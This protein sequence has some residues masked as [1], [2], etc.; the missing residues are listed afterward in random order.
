M[1]RDKFLKLASEYEAY[2]TGKR[3]DAQHPMHLLLHRELPD[4]LR[5]VT[6]NSGAFKFDGSDGLANVTI[7]PWVATFHQQITESATT[8]YYVVWLLTE[9][10]KSIILE[11]GL[12]ATQFSTLYG[13]NKEALTAIARASQ[14]VLA[15][16]KPFI[17][18]IFSVNLLSKAI[19]GEIPALGKGYDHRAYGKAAVVSVSYAVESLPTNEM[20]LSDYLCFVEL[21]QA[22]VSSSI[23]PS[24]DELVLDELIDVERQGNT[25]QRIVEQSEFKKK[26]VPVR[27]DGVGKSGGDSRRY[28]RESKQ[29][30]DLGERLVFEYLKERLDQS[31]RNDLAN[32]VVWHQEFAEDR[33]P[34]WDIT[35]Y[36]PITNEEVFIEV[37]A[38][39]GA[40]I[41]EVILTPKEWDAA[42]KH[43]LQYCIYLVTNVLN[44]NPKLEVVHDPANE[45]V[46][47]NFSIKEAS[48]E[49]RF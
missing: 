30:G 28:S 1:L 40:T 17:K 5:Q 31:G 39:K 15:V 11:L 25:K 6:P 10:R 20:M 42:K 24:V 46:Q 22:L 35:S 49:L 44:L 36:D 18:S 14:K 3:V 29:I 34:G 47:G 33:T 32:K 37:K 45:V 27:K 41:R 48:W 7:V 38:S 23:M 26:P 12:G 9:D 13:E 2:R 8:G 19:E 4:A 21:Y 16:A 43:R